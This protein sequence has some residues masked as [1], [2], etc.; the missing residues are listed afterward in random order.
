MNTD[1][2]NDT[3]ELAFTIYYPS[4]I[5]TQRWNDVLFL[6]NAE[7]NGGY[8]F[9]AYQWYKNDEAIAGETGSYLYVPEG[10]DRTA[11]YR[12]EV[13]RSDDGVT[14]FTC[15]V[16]PYDAGGASL[17]LS[18]N[19]LAKGAVMKLGSP[20]KGRVSVYGVSGVLVEQHELSEGTNLL[21]APAQTG[22]YLLKV[23]L[24]NGMV[25]TFHLQVVE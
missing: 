25:R 17:T 18:P 14:T 9:S 22:Y 24:D 6:Q 12:V 4:S 13:T 19:V 10:L 20:E 3:L 23:N 21:Q 15:P 8:S 5:V 11:E 1:C 2:G 7:Y 16:V